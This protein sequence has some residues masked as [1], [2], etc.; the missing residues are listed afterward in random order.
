M[1]TL[2]VKNFSV[3]DNA[4]IDVN[5]I[6]LL[7]GP[8]ATGKSILAKLVYF[9]KSLSSELKSAVASDY[10][11]KELNKSLRE[12]FNKVF[13]D[14]LWKQR[15]FNI[16][17]SFN[18]LSIEINNEKSKSYKSLKL[19]YSPNIEKLY[20]SCR[21]EYQKK[22]SKGSPGRSEDRQKVLE[23]ISSKL[24]RAFHGIDR[25]YPEFITASRSFFAYIERNIFPFL[26]STYSLDMML[27]KFGQFLQN[28]KERY[29]S[30]SKIKK[31]IDPDLYKLCEEVIRGNYEYSGDIEFI[32]RP[33]NKV[34]L[35][36]D[37]SSG[38]QEVTPLLVSLMVLTKFGKDHFYLFIE[39]PEAHL[40][41]ESQR[42]V[43]D[44]LSLVHNIM[45]K[46]TGFFITTHSPYIL[47]AFNNLIQA[48]NTKAELSALRAK[49]KI[50]N[51]EF[52]QCIKKLKLIVPEKKHINFND[53][54]AYSVESGQTKN[55]LCY[56][57]KIVDAFI[58]DSISSSLNTTFNSLLDLTE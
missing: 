28:I 22:I 33:D 57:T 18:D 20:L 45:K 39:E 32:Q 16:H 29:E 24:D 5:R 1:E 10:G 31:I 35:I 30:S 4:C 2:T 17:Y 21:K 19:I 12:S 55:I 58:I 51:N 47:T 23:D 8:Q 44:I 11:K 46:N 41:P 9:F 15:L 27:L 42:K 7:I 54:S 6:T 52:D 13:P 53:I 37:S 3:I 36:R 34:V 40:Y 56:D 14:Y 25:Y 50:S 26:A 38:Q 43:V 49:G 48:D